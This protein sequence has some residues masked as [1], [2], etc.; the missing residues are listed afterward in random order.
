MKI[1]NKNGSAKFRIALAV[2]FYLILGVTN[3]GLKLSFAQPGQN[4]NYDF[5]KANG[6]YKDGEYDQAILEYGK[7]I[8]G[9]FESGNIYYNLGNCYFKKGE[10]G[11]ALLNYEKAGLFIPNDSDLK[12]NYEYTR[13]LLNIVAESDSMNMFVRLFNK[14]FSQSS[15]NFQ[16]ILLAVFFALFFLFLILNRFFSALRRFSKPLL[17]F[18]LL[19][20]IITGASLFWKI[21]YLKKGAIVLTKEA[22]ARFA[23][24]EGATIYFKLTQGSRIEVI[25]K[26][27]NWYRVKR[28]DGKIGWVSSLSLELI[29]D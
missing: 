25:E 2:I 7:V 18:L 5:D 10:L 28:S 6:L 24:L 21:N 20:C 11:R 4:L 22:E 15:I 3:Y 13:T 9:G 17:A 8:E 29:F 16:T 12:S 26:V 1:M 19:M 23:P 27:D 14:L